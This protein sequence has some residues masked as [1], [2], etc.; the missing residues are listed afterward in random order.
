MT[1]NIQVN[2][3]PQFAKGTAASDVSAACWQQALQN[4]WSRA[5]GSSS[6]SA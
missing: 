2:A 4:G 3:L 6:T 5:N 1:L